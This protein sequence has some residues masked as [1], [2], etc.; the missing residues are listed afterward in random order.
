MRRPALRA[1]TTDRGSAAAELV[2]VVPLVCSFLGLFVVGGVLW[3]DRQVLTEAARSAAEAASMNPTALS[4]GDAAR[5][6]VRDDLIGSRLRCRN[7]RTTTGTAEFRPGGEVSVTISCQALL[8]RLPFLDVSSSVPI[9]V[10]A[11]A[12]LEPYRLL[13]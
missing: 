6:V 11:A 4:A 1:T 2:L 5:S 12:A 9:R 3:F 13:G 8:P 10:G 7:L